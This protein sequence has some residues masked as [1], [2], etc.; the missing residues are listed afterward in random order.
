EK[1]LDFSCKL[2]IP[3]PYLIEYKEAVIFALM[4]WLRVHSKINVLRTVTGA[5]RDTS[6][7]KIASI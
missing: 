3:E 5:T 7:G 6:S 4:G 2:V 1:Y